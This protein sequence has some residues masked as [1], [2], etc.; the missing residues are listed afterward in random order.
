MLTADEPREIA[1][2]EV[3]VSAT[4]LRGPGV[5]RIELLDEP[6]NIW[7]EAIGGEA[8]TLDLAP[9]KPCCVFR[10]SRQ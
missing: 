5:H 6:A 9:R 7:A 2:K 8:G 10:S 3:A 1:R 4:F